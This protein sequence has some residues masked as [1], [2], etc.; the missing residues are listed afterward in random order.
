[1]GAVVF[2]L[3]TLVA[4]AA[5][6]QTPPET[7]C[8]LPVPAPSAAP[9]P[10]GGPVI[11]ALLLCF[12]TQGGTS[13]IDPATYLYY[14]HLRPSESSRG[15][16]RVFD[17]GAERTARDDFGRLWATGFL[18]DLEIET[19]PY[20]FANGAHGVVVVYRLR[21]RPRVKLVEY[22]GLQRVGQSD[23]LDALKERQLSIRLDAF[24]DP[25]QLRRASTVIRDLLAEKGFPYAEV[26]PSVAAPPDQPQLARVRFAISEGPQVAIRAVQFLGNAAFSD[27]ALRRVLKHSRPRGLLSL[28]A[29]GGTYSEDQFADDAVRIEEFY[30]DEGFI[31]AKVGQ[32]TLR[33]LDDSSDGSTRWVQL[34]VPITEGSRHTVGTLTV[35]GQTVFT[36]AVLVP[37]FGLKSGDVY[38]QARVRKGFERARDVYGA[39]G[40]FEFTAYPDITPRGSSAPAVADVTIRIQEGKPYS[41]HRIQFAGNTQTRDDVIR[42]ELGVAEGARFNTEALKYSLRRI[43]QLGYFKPLDDAAV[44]VTRVAGTDDQVDITIKVEEQNRNQLQFGAGMSQYEGVFGNV[45]FTT[46]NLLGR[47]ES[48]TVAG[49][50]GTRSRNYQ[51]A[52]TEPFAFNRAVSMG[53]SLYSRKVDFAL[54]TPTIDYSEVRSGANLTTGMSWRRFTRLYFTYGYEIVDT[55]MTDELSTSLGG[56]TTS[57]TLLAQEGRFTES[58]VTPSIVYNT[59]DNPFTPRQGLRL[60]ATSQYAGGWLGGTSRYVRPE[61]Q[62]ILY[63]PMTRRTAVGLRVN[64]GAIWNLSRQELPY[65]QRYFLGGEQQIRGVNV[66]SVG[67]LSESNV[68]TGGT[69]F[70]LVNLEVYYDLL[71]QLRTLL[72]HDAGQAFGEREAVDLRNLR[73]ST[74]VEVRVNVPML[75]VPFRLIYAWNFYR[76]AFQPARTLKFAVG[77]TF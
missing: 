75:N 28:V 64:A 46:A 68:A 3:A 61:V 26:T 6:A 32:P 18:D 13:S 14:V 33:V 71:P 22:D 11:V 51:L 37:L 77:T 2:A 53:G 58:S 23:V 1:M 41:V 39:A 16:W 57:S 73:T 42:R 56:G 35:D 72:F 44:D 38:R 50:A 27:E 19:V 24:L 40:Y 12:D 20:P 43:N 34:R 5:D 8:G 9:D 36:E 66:R 70:A 7:V 63:V 47:G 67:P 17:D 76:D 49:Q 15:L 65:Y 10:A 59:V 29:G 30:R 74:G 48:L 25:L 60:S 55:A 21:E 52:F 54:N 45:S 31:N 69:R 62:G 4:G